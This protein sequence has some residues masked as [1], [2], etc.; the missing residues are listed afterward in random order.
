MNAIKLTH[1]HIFIITMTASWVTVRGLDLEFLKSW[2]R[3]RNC[4][5][6][7]YDGKPNPNYP[8]GWQFVCRNDDENNNDQMNEMYTYM[9]HH[10]D[11]HLYQ[12][13]NQFRKRSLFLNFFYATMEPDE[14]E[15]SWEQTERFDNGIYDRPG[16]WAPVAIIDFS[17]HNSCSARDVLLCI[18]CA[19]KEHL[20]LLS[21]K[22][23]IITPLVYGWTQLKLPETALT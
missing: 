18:S 1:L 8:D 14:Q 13:Q 7:H 11:G 22:S 20:L 4:S 9:A 12:I 17:D 6:H 5:Q 3:N 10:M 19:T 21:A 2:V 23:L 16:K 15:W